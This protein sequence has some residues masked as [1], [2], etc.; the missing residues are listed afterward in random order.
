MINFRPHLKS[1]EEY[2]QLHYR[3]K[4]TIKGNLWHLDK[5]IEY[6]Q[7]YGL[8]DIRQITSRHITEYRKF[9]Y[10]RINDRGETDSPASQNRH[11]EA[12]KRFFAFLKQEGVI[13]HDPTEKSEYARV[14]KRLPKSALSDQEINKLLACPDTNTL[15][16]YRD[17][18]MMEVLYS[19]GIRQGELINLNLT[20]V[21]LED[22]FLRINE[23]K[24]G[25]DRMVPL[26][27]IARQFLEN[28]IK[29]IRPS[30]HNARKREALF[31]SKKGNRISKTALVE[32]IEKYVKAS[33]IEKHVTTHTFRRTC[34]T[35]MIKNDCNA[36]LVKE[37]LGHSDMRTIEV[38][39]DLT[40]VE[41]KKAHKKHHPRERQKAAF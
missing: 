13:I 14:P 22:G 19:S 25:H 37:L 21:D 2:L 24:G 34:A 41:L 5:F 1:F 31:L 3:A 9:R 12:L 23:G 29:G 18:T 32:R 4:A 11:L 15:M 38:Y 27:R 20:D 28:Y 7:R 8:D 35:G 30:F 10:F 36:Y 16:G 17:R 26:G 6:L 33:G 40:I 39:C